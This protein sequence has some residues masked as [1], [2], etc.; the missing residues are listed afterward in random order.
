MATLKLSRPHAPMT[1]AVLVQARYV[2]QLWRRDMNHEF[3]RPVVNG[4]VLP[5]PLGHR[6]RTRL[7]EFTPIFPG[8][9]DDRRACR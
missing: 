2:A 3:M 1:L 4:R 5:A 8:Q 9:E 6:A 7:A